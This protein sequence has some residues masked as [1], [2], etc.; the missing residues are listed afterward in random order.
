MTKKTKPFTQDDLRRIQ[1]NE[2]KKND[3]GVPS[4]GLAA[5]IQSNLDSKSGKNGV[6]NG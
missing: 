2:D 3:G 5:K 6:K 4:G 1:R